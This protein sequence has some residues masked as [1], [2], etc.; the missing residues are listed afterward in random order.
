MSH[1]KT[2]KLV[3]VI[4]WLKILKYFISTRL[5]HHSITLGGHFGGGIERMK[6]WFDYF[7]VLKNSK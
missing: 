1:G 5:N 3:Q 6:I 4:L 2:Y 7:M